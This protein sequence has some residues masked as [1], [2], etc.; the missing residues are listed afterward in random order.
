MC[1]SSWRSSLCALS[2]ILHNRTKSGDVSHLLSGL[3]WLSDASGPW[4]SCAALITQQLD[5]QPSHRSRMQLVK[6]RVCLH[7]RSDCGRGAKGRQRDPSA[8]QGAGIIRAMCRGPSVGFCGGSSLCGPAGSPHRAT[9]CSTVRA[10]GHSRTSPSSAR[11]G[12]LSIHPSAA[13]WRGELAMLC[14]RP[15]RSC[16]R[17]ELLNR[18]WIGACSQPPLRAI[19]TKREGG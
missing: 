12:E 14:E 19:G 8:R 1:L 4:P 3:A 6:A 13:V 18:P 7:G 10:A 17:R 5:L 11:R 2:S 15:R 16:R 9:G